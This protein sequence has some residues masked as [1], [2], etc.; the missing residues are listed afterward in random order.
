MLRKR[1]TLVG[2]FRGCTT[3]GEGTGV[4]SGGLGPSPSPPTVW[5]QFAPSLNGEDCMGAL[6]WFPPDWD[7]ATGWGV[8][9]CFEICV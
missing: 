1:K 6:L 9:C 5:L 4:G 8:P 2:G 7:S 3:S